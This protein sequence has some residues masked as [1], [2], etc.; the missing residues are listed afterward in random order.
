M[1]TIARRRFGR[2]T[3]E[4][5]VVPDADATLFHMPSNLKPEL[6]ILVADIFPRGF[7]LDKLVIN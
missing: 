4:I 3:F 1:R 7:C 2:Q 6:A 5:V